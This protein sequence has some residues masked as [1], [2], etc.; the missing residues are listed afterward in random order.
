VATGSGR[1]GQAARPQR[2]TSL[3]AQSGFIASSDHG[4]GNPN[5]PANVNRRGSATVRRR[6][7][8][9]RPPPLTPANPLL[10]RTVVWRDPL[11]FLKPRGWGSPPIAAGGIGIPGSGSNCVGIRY[12]HIVTPL[13]RPRSGK[14]SDS[15]S[16][17]KER[18]RLCL[19]QVR[20]LPK[21]R[22]PRLHVERI[23]RQARYGPGSFK[24]SSSASQTFLACAYTRAQALPARA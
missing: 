18:A 12:A 6:S 3:P 15:Q 5:P 14:T 17:G 1:P 13:H 4:R 7:P 9:C 8:T 20:A 16:H 22:P 21:T 23:S 11:A 19:P 24:A 2:R 10:R